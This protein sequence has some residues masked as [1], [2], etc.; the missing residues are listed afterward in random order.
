MTDW[1]DR[2]RGHGERYEE[3][4]V[5]F[6]AEHQA[7]EDTIGDEHQAEEGTMDAELNGWRMSALYGA[8]ELERDRNR[9]LI[10]IGSLPPWPRWTSPHNNLLPSGHGWGDALERYLGGGLGPGELYVVGAASAKAGKTALVMQLAEG[11]ALR[12]AAVALG[13]DG[14]AQVGA[15]L[16][17]A[18][19]AALE[20]ATSNLELYGD[21][22]TP[23]VVVSEMPASALSRRTLGRWVGADANVFRAG[24]TALKRASSPEERDGIELAW[25]RAHAALSCGLLSEAR[26][27]HTLQVPGR[28]VQEGADATWKL[29]RYVERWRARLAERYQRKVVPVLVVDPA[30]RFQAPLESEVMALSELSAT[31]RQ[32]VTGSVPGQMGPWCGLLTSDATKHSASGRAAKDGDD[33]ATAV[34]RGSYHLI[35]EVSAAFVISRPRNSIINAA[36]DA[37]ESTDDLG[38]LVANTERDTRC[39]DEAMRPTRV[40]IQVG[41]A[42]NRHGRNSGGASAPAPRFDWWPPRQRLYPVGIDELKRRRRAEAQLAEQLVESKKAGKKSS[43]ATPNTNTYEDML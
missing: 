29:G 26:T 3:E 8:D 39:Y 11:L 4:P 21:V 9:E 18:E 7:E 10:G 36:H 37:D 23:V 12:S 14:L 43:S 19:L 20:A 15:G 31:I 40:E 17:V 42:Y 16:S 38:E 2:A 34:M 30:Q 35:H 5:D 24:R 41:V 13:T 28:L 27:S 6:G 1:N 32:W 22:L 33:L 25:Q